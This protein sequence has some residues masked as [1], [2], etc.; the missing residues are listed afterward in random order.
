MKFIRSNYLAFGLLLFSATFLGCGK[1]L[2]DTNVNPNAI[3]AEQIN[4]SYIMTQ[5]LGQTATQVSLWALTGNVTQSLLSE[6]MQY[7]Q[8]DYLESAVTNTYN[9][10]TKSWDAGDFYLPLA[11]AAYL[12]KQAIHSSDS[13][14]LRGVSLVLTSFWYGYYAS[15]WGDV[16]YSEAI[17]GPEGNLRPAFDKQQDIFKGILQDLE[18][19][20]SIL[21]NATVSSSTQF[22][23]ILYNGDLTKWR[24]FANS[25]H[26]RFLMRLSEKAADMQTMGVDV[27]AEF[28]K[29][30]S[31]PNKYPI[32]TNA[33]NN[34]SINFPGTVAVDSWPLGPLNKP[35]RSEF[36]RRKPGSTIIN[37]LKNNEDPRLTVWFN[38]VQVPT[39][40]R[41]KG[42]ERV[43][44]KDNDGEV[45]RYFKTYKADL[46][47]AL[48]VG[49]DIAMADPDSRNEKDQAQISSA[50]ALDPSIYTSSAANPF[51]SYLADMWAANANPLVNSVLISASEVNFT[52]AEAAVRGWISGSASDYYKK[53]IEASLD[54]YKISDG[55]KKVY[56]KTT[57]QI[58]SFDL[59]TFLADATTAFDNATDKIEPIITQAWAADF[60]TAD[61]AAWCNWRRTGYP[62]LG[63]NVINGAQGDK[64]PVRFAYGDNPK[65]FNGANVDIAVQ[66]LQPTVDDQW[67]KTWLLQGTG[68]PW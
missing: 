4:P 56:N 57:H 36:Y 65:N 5:A 48:Y 20:N 21:T 32:I 11:N 7:S 15:A 67:S 68:K 2:T 60:G 33:T 27:K 43:I 24:A 19:A 31:D 8:R 16:P 47:T 62:D 3:S 26:L 59:N 41:D 35:D 23:D 63:K 66:N 53:G 17:K 1:S 61:M 40:I 28:N 52:L 29:I 44:V 51:V 25:L 55:D 37:F 39:L 6:L 46:D 30:V 58:V 10:Q 49:L 14:F 45:R 22:A 42:A 64:M 9:W 18:T 12:R 13:V 38:A 54:Q 34:A 50:A